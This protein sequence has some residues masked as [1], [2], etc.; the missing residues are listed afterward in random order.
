VLPAREALG[1]ERKPVP[2]DAREPARLFRPESR[3]PR[4]SDRVR[5]E[6]RAETRVDIEASQDGLDRVVSHG[7]PLASDAPG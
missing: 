1:C 5:Q 4:R 2:V 6:A 3:R 7:L